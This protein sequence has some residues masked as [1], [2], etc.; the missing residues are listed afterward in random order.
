MRKS[1]LTDDS[2]ILKHDKATLLTMES[3]FSIILLPSAH[4]LKIDHMILLFARVL[5]IDTAN[6]HCSCLR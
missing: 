2:S 6:Q 1:N 4:L 5:E 3:T